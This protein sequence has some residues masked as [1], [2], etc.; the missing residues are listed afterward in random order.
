MK[1]C[2]V[3]GILMMIGVLSLT[4]AGFQAPAG[5]SA[6]ALADTKI[7]KVKDN[8]YLIT[9]SDA[10]AANSNK[11]SGGNTAVFITD[12]GVVLV[13]TKLPGW[14]PTLMQRIKSVTEKT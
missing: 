13:D 9:G 6:A 7:E 11:F 2:L 5:P 4:V 14:G 8:L 12:K 10:S 3:L 1:R